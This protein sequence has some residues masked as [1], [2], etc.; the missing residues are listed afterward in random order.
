MKIINTI[1]KTQFPPIRHFES[2]MPQIV[3]IFHALFILVLFKKK[4]V[5]SLIQFPLTVVSLAPS[6]GLH[7]QKRSLIDLRST[8]GPGGGSWLR[9]VK[10]FLKAASNFLRLLSNRTQKTCR[11][12]ARA[13]P[14]LNLKCEILSQKGP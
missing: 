12:M 13:G 11:Q 4:S 5:P 8:R 10:W 6:R 9:L 3:S 1:I 14:N 7:E 2:F